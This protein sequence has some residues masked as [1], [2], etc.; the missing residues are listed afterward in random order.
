VKTWDDALVKPFT[1]AGNGSGSDP[2]VFAN[3]LRSL[4]GMKNRL[5]SGYP[6]RPMISLAM[7]ARRSR[8]TLRQVMDQIQSRKGGMA[9]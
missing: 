3:L 6:A 4:F 1:V 7:G 8:R 5:V 2:D 9:C